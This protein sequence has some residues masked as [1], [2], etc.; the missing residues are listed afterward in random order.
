MPRGEARRGPETGNY[1]S[2][3][4]SIVMLHERIEHEF[5]LERSHLAGSDHWPVVGAFVVP[6]AAVVGMSLP[7]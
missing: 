6:G 5:A 2:R 7:S 3:R 4:A 1:Q